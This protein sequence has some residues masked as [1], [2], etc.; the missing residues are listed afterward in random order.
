MWGCLQNSGDT[1][2]KKTEPHQLRN[3][4]IEE[5]SLLRW[6]ESL[7][8]KN[9]LLPVIRFMVMSVTIASLPVPS[10]SLSVR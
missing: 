9:G 10:L 7:F 1:S 8:K 5:G 6:V 3:L 4:F 2:V